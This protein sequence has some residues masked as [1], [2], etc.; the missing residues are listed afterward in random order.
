M[1]QPGDRILAVDGKT[2]PGIDP[3]AR[4]ERFRDQ[5]A[6]HECPGKQV[7]GCEAE[8]PVA[9][10]IG[11]DG[12]VKTIAVTP[13]YER[14]SD[15]TLVG[16]SYG[17]EPTEI[18]IGTAA[19]RSWDTM[20]LVVERTG[21]VFARIFESEQRKQISGIVGISDVANQTIEVG[22][23]PSLLLLGLV[24]LSLGVINLLP[25]LPLDGGHIFWSLVE[26]LRGQPVS[27]R[28][29]ERATV[30]GFVLV[31]MLFFIGLNNDVGRLGGDGYDVR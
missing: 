6:S 18:G 29:M 7:Q 16:F 14:A 28:V 13:V 22:V 12:E 3:E 25:F 8:T 26:K 5:V 31:A 11:R 9:L 2:Y 23:W 4:L 10:R 30:V 1:L 24:S 17:T 27:L 15:R 21:S 20:W 19:T